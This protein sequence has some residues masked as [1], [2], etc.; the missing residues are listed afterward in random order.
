MGAGGVGNGLGTARTRGRGRSAG[1]GGGRARHRH[2]RYH[3][4]YLFRC[5]GCVTGTGTG[6]GAGGHQPSPQRVSPRGRRPPPHAEPHVGSPQRQVRTP[7]VSLTSLPLW[8]L[9]SARHS[10]RCGPHLSPLP[11][12]LSDASNRLATSTRANPPRAKYSLF[13]PYTPTFSC[14]RPLLTSLPLPIIAL[15]RLY[16][17]PPLAARTGDTQQ[18]RR[19]VTTGTQHWAACPRP[20]HRPLTTMGVVG[21]A[22]VGATGRG[23]HPAATAAHQGLPS[24]RPA[25]VGPAS[26]PAV[27][28][29]LLMGP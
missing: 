2:R 23:F 8:C 7:P 3:Y 6:T 19:A 28:R 21:A 14:R 12:S 29:A 15:P 13:D 25:A 9:S 27:C 20:A 18:G 4:H 1:R 5:R 17:A 16:R 22:A 10:G 11:L 24:R 26:A